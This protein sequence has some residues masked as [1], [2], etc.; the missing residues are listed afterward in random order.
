MEVEV[1]RDA[2]AAGN[3]GK[4]R[5]DRSRDAAQIDEQ[6][7]ALDGQMV[8]HRPFEAAADG[9]AGSL[10]RIAGASESAEPA[11]SVGKRARHPKTGERKSAGQIGQHIRFGEAQAPAKRD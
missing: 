11:D 10:I 6:V 4:A 7:F 1:G 9:P 2:K 5:S 8:V 3:A